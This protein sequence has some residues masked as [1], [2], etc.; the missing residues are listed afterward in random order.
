MRLWSFFVKFN[1]RT[2][3]KMLMTYTPIMQ[4]YVVKCTIYNRENLL[5]LELLLLT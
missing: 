2:P 4:T 5:I 1:R 3:L